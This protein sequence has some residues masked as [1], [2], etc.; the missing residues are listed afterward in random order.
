MA[1]DMVM[2]E[3]LPAPFDTQFKLLAWCSPAY[4]TGAFSY[5][6]GMEWAVERG[7]VNSLEGLLS[8]VTAVIERGGGWVDA[9]LFAHAW[10]A[11]RAESAESA[12]ST[13]VADLDAI[14][15]L[16]SAFRGSAE[17]ALE[18]RQQG[19]SFLEVT[20]KAWP[21]PTLDAFAARQTRA[22]ASDGT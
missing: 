20:R 7:T 22:G 19:S 18:S 16:A 1:M 4:P 9:V 13:T 10:R 17:T 5:S 2:D 21:H 12:G 6:H 15:E 11:A 8:F 14:A 3:P